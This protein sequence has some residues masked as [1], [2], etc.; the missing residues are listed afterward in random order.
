MDI[1]NQ[2]YPPEY[3]TLGIEK[4]STSMDIY[5][6]ALVLLSILSEEKLNYTKEEILNNKP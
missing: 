4:L 6:T 5:H 2:L 3:F 1:V